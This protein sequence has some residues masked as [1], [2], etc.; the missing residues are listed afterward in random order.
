MTDKPDKFEKTKPDIADRFRAGG[1]EFTPEVTEVFDD[2]VKA[3][4]PFYDDI[5]KM[6][7]ELSDWLLPDHGVYADLGASTCTTLA[8]ICNRHPARRFRA[9][10]YDE[11]E[12][13]LQ[14]GKEKVAQLNL[15][16]NFHIQRVQQPFKHRN[17]DLTVALF[18]LQFLPQRE[19]LDV[20]TA[21]RTAADATGGALVVAEKIRP[22]HPLIAEIGNDVSHDFKATQGIDDTAI[23]SKARALRGVLIPAT[24]EQLLADIEKAGWQHSDV[25]FRWYQWVVV[26]AFAS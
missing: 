6:V 5:Q 1:W 7:C 13:M 8:A 9:E 18:L 24:L 21:A 23:R 17:A 3:S 20:L 16:S 19:R 10:L 11:S 14:K 15:V 26:L 2:H 25:I 22:T 4:V 12:S